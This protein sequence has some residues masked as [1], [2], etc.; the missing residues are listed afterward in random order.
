MHIGGEN[1]PST[2]HQFASSTTN[3]S[4]QAIFDDID[5]ALL[6]GSG[7]QH[8]LSA[9]GH[10]NKIALKGENNNFTINSEKG[11][12]QLGAT[13]SNQTATISNYGNTTTPSEAY[14]N[15]EKSVWRYQGD[16]QQRLFVGGKNN[17][18]TL[19][20]SST[21]EKPGLNQDDK[22][23][24][25]GNGNQITA[26]T[27]TGDDTITIK[28]A[29]GGFKTEVDG[30]EGKNTLLLEKGNWRTRK[31]ADGT[32]EYT[33]FDA[34]SPNEKVLQTVKVKNFGQAQFIDPKPVD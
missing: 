11:I 34:D 17:K 1:T 32:T 2:V 3:S 22:L 29:K 16:G 26:D 10:I 18:V 20:T 28:L 31:L 7:N 9:W 24:L 15:G 19:V 27:G 33:R 14:L 6:E 5:Q 4:N 8:R 23:V 13:G 21:I 25:A 12:S 30:G